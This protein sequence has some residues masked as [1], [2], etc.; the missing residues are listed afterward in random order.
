MT[1][2]AYKKQLLAEYR[3]Y[4]TLNDEEKADFLKKSKAESVHKTE[5]EK[6]MFQEA[7]SGNL[8]AIKD[9][10]SAIKGRLEE[11]TRQSTPHT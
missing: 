5:E 1:T 3:L 9:R 2:E 7:I 8:L 4:A 6:A 10:L 11:Q